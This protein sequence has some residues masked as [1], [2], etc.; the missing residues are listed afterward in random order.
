M[1]DTGFVRFPG[2]LDPKAAEFRPTN[3]YSHN[4]I[5]LLPTQIYY[6][7]PP[8]PPPQVVPLCPPPPYVPLPPPLPP[9]TTATR[10]LLL[11]SVPIG[12]SESEVRRELE[13]FGDVRAVQMERVR[14]GIVTVYFYDLRDATAAEAEIREQHLRQQSRLSKHFQEIA[15]NNYELENLVVAPPPPPPP[16]RGR[17]LISGCAVWAQFTIPAV[18]GVSDGHNQGTLVIFNL[19]SSVSTTS[20]RDIFQAFGPVKEL[21]ETPLKRHQRFVEFYDVRH[22]AKALSEM[23]GK[24]I[25][26]SHVVIEFSRPGGHVKRFSKSAQTTIKSFN[27]SSN[28]SRKNSTCFPLPPPPPPP[29]P[30]FHRKIPAFHLPPRCYNSQTQTQTMGKKSSFCKRNPNGIGGGVV[31]ASSMA[32]VCVKSEVD[33]GIRGC[34]NNNPMKKSSKKSANQQQQTST[35]SNRPLKG[36]QARNFDPRFLINEDAIMESNC[37]DSRTTVMIKNIPNKYSQK[38]LLN[39]LDNHCIHCNEQVADGGDDQPLSSYDFVYL[40]IDFINKCNVGYGFV[41]MTSPEATWRLYKAFHLQNW[42]VFNSKKICEVTYARLQGVEALKEH[43]KNSK[44]PCE[45]EEYLPVVFAPPRDGRQLTEPNPIVGRVTS[46]S[47]QSP[48]TTVSSK[49]SEAEDYDD[50]KTVNNNNN[51]NGCHNGGGGS[52]GGG[53]R[54]S[55]GG[56]SC[57]GGDSGGDVIEEDE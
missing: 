27:S 4:Q 17:G 13:V 26:G 25:H 29:P 1:G 35:K 2:S 43:F 42:E 37:R 21:R 8:P 41:N 22:A 54:N 40:P 20:L 30:S 12:V 51:N 38:L 32:A 49:S 48:P 53:V 36:R 3:L 18:A 39:M 44:F 10:V 5:T 45:A 34:N 55:G 46:T 52:D 33:N 23:N 19:D 56:S 9:S 31:E 11:S 6:P 7:Y 50:D 24:E 57:N 15:R 16:P 14:D 28:Y 47:L